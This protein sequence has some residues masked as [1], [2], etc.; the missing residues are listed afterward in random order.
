MRS[1]PGTQRK[2]LIEKQLAQVEKLFLDALRYRNQLEKTG[3]YFEKHNMLKGNLKTKF[4]ST[5]KVIDDAID[6]Y[7]KTFNIDDSRWQGWQDR[8]KSVEPSAELKTFLDDRR[9]FFERNPRQAGR[10]QNFFGQMLNAKSL[11][12]LNEAMG[13]IGMDINQVNAILNTNLIDSSQALI[14][15]REYELGKYMLALEQLAELMRAWARVL[16]SD[17]GVIEVVGSQALNDWAATNQD[18]PD[19][20]KEIYSTSD[21]GKRTS[22]MRA[23]ANDLDTLA[24][25]FTLMAANAEQKLKNK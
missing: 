12:D 8:I 2:E 23:K 3:D 15:V 7:K 16:R 22:L 21:E 18:E 5:V 6:S 20:I 13:S 1:A 17:A 11:K 14:K 24:E 25:V 4:D 9:K 19:F 10:L